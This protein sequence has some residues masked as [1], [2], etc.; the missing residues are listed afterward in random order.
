M[1]AMAETRARELGAETICLNAVPDA[2]RFYMRHGY[3][4]SRWE[5][6]TENPTEIPVVKHLT[7]APSR[8]AAV[9]PGLHVAC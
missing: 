2:Y 4:P 9:A 6:C 7:Q 5:G 3:A 8:H 1:L